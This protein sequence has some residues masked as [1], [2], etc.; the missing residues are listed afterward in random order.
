MHL[1]PSTGGRILA[2]IQDGLDGAQNA[3]LASAFVSSS[4]IQLL[5]ANID[6]LLGRGG[7]VSL[8]ATFNGG[9]FTDPNFFKL[10]DPLERRFPTQVE[11]YLYP[12]PTTLFHAKTFLF[13]SADKSWSGIVGSANLTHQ[14]LTGANFEIS[15]VATPIAHAEIVVI[16][17]ELSRLRSQGF[18]RR[19]T[20][21]LCAQLVATENDGDDEDPEESARAERTTRAKQKQVKSAL[22]CIKPSPLPALPALLQPATVYVEDLCA[23]GIGIATDDDLADLSVSVD[24]G[25]FVRA[26]VLAKE[27]TK[28]IGFVSENTKKG[29]SFSLIDDGVR[30]TVKTARKSIGKTLGLRAVDFGYLRWVPHRFYDDALR[31]IAS[32]PDVKAARAAV[33]RANE[34][35]SKHIDKVGRS[36]K[37]NMERVVAALKLQPKNEW[38]EQLLQK[39]SISAKVSTAKMREIILEHI[40]ERNRARVSAPLV[41]SQLGRLTFTPRSFAFPLAQSQGGDSHY[42]HKH[43]LANVVWA[44]TDRVLKRTNEE[45][46]TG[47]LF[48]Y[49]DARRLLNKGRH[50]HETAEL[51]EC[52]A[53]WLD[54]K[55]SIEVAVDQFREMYGPEPFTW[56]LGDLVSLVAR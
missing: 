22:S 31:A 16:R 29:H 4:G 35:I 25:V 19:L 32:K 56:E 20:S 33:G 7:T 14:A 13:E 55:T 15:A 50:N 6:A 42:G 39:H 37:K 10:L 24:L 11:V 26:K 1:L 43:F 40:V 46:G 48:E 5:L 51:A 41:W 12:N 27:T 52:A 47:A 30:E 28:K 54:P 23:T 45:S 38:D 36:F 3:I 18:F 21:D 2:A 49:L 44:C 17:N 9:A 53:S 34:A 8:Y